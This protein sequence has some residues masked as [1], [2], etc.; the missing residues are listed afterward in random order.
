[1]RA[2][3]AVDLEPPKNTDTDDILVEE[4]RDHVAIAVVR[5]VAM[6]QQQALKE[7]ELRD[8][9]VGRV[10]SLETF[11]ARDTN[12]DVRGLDHADIVGTITNGKGHRIPSFLDLW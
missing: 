3:C 7:A 6:D 1:M 5:P 2:P 4:V 8:G 11:L 9:V 10:N 12:A